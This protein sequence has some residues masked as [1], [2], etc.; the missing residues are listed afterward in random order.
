MPVL[1]APPPVTY[2]P[3][4][5]R[6]TTLLFTSF[7]RFSVP[8]YEKMIETGILNDEDK[9]ELLEGLVVLKMSRN[10]AHDGS[11]DLAQD[12][13]RRALP[14]GWFIRAQ[15]AVT[16]SESVPEPDIAVVRGTVR[17]FLRRHPGSADIGMLVEIANVSRDRDLVDKAR[18]YA[19]DG[20]P[21]YWVVNLID[22]RVEVFS[23]PSGPTAAP[24]FGQRVEYRV[25][26]SIPLTLDGVVVGSI[27]VQELLP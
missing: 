1:T 14:I 23:L 12:V 11:I 24:A 19:R 15:E 6:T 21:Y 25:G 26:D 13:L 7:R 5:P 8:E 3:V 4:T 20:I 27:Q 10:P 22:N 16:L 18:I 17:S 2:Q 9:V